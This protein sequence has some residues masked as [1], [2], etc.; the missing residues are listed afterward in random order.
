MDLLFRQWLKKQS[1]P[2]LRD[3]KKF[4][5]AKIEHFGRRVFYPGTHKGYVFLAEESVYVGLSEKALLRELYVS[6]LGFKMKP[7][8][9]KHAARSEEEISLEDKARLTAITLSHAHRNNQI[10]WYGNLAGYPQGFQVVNN[11]KILILESPEFIEPR[12]GSCEFTLKLIHDLF[13]EQAPIFLAW[14]KRAVKILRKGPPFD[15][16]QVLII[17]GGVE[18][19]KT[20]LVDELITPC[21]NGRQADA[22]PHFQ[23]AT[24][25]NKDLSD[26][27]TWKLDD[28]IV[29]KFSDQRQRAEFLK[30]VAADSFLRIEAKGLNAI[31]IP[32]YR[33]LVL[34]L[35]T[36]SENFRVLPPLTPDL[37]DKILA[38]KSSKAELPAGPGHRETIHKKLQKERAAF[39]QYLED[40][41]VPASVRSEG[42]FGILPFQHPDI[43]EGIQNASNDPLL[44]ELIERYLLESKKHDWAERAATMWIDLNQ[45][46]A[47]RH[48]LAQICPN[49]HCFCRMLTNLAKS[50]SHEDAVF[51]LPDQR[52]GQPYRIITREYA[53]KLEKGPA[54]LTESERMGS[55]NISIVQPA[56]SAKS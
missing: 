34:L 15:P 32:T 5:A 17:G 10:D 36:E 1:K 19:G 7:R 43:L 12:K 55:I 54:K 40:Y 18:H 31:N 16:M 41:V 51:K 14:L 50:A 42:R 35:N 2:I 27:G 13:G 44:Y 47:Y 20:L 33:A 26:S 9:S 56:I 46:D 23:H 4:E 22:T 37:A 38:L 11:R 45:V 52:K 21:L 6:G 25:F 8:A 28:P 24:L 30:K 29:L 53:D 3:Q 49:Y 39:L 48:L